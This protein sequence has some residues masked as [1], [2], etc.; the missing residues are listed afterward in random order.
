MTSLSH[1]RL[2]GIWEQAALQPPAR[3]AFCLLAGVCD[4]AQIVA[5]LSVGERDRRLFLLRRELFGEQIEGLTECPKCRSRVEVRFGISEIAGD[6]SPAA[7]PVPLVADGYEIRWRLPTCGD[8]AELADETAPDRIR[9]RL[10]ERCLLAVRR[11]REEVSLRECPNSAIEGVFAAM[12]MADP[13]GDIRLD[14]G[15]PECGTT[16]KSAFDIGAYLWRELDVWA[17][18]LLRD[19]HCLA[20]AFGWSE[21]DILAMS[22][23]RR[24]MY[25]DLMEA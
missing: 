5:A 25:L 21:R 17:R 12:A 1:S 13:L 8:L 3:R 11:E 23:G 16:W 4:D 15:C 2:L 24:Q 22:S 19:V 9:E 20:S 18:R 14:L 10:L 6:A 7:G